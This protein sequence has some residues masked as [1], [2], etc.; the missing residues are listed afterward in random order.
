[1]LLLIHLVCPSQLHLP[2]IQHTI[3]IQV[4]LVELLLASSCCHELPLVNNSIL[5]CIHPMSILRGLS[6]CSTPPCQL[7]CI[8]HTIPIHIILVELLLAPPCCTKLLR[9]HHTILVG[10]H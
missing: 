4:V 8:P 5:V 10:V 2:S 9:I 7:I 3:P 6:L 1:M